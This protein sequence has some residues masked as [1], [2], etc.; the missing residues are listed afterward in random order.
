ML[1]ALVFALWK[2]VKN[3]IC[4]VDELNNEF[5]THISNPN[6]HHTRYTDEDA[7]NAVDASNKFIER[8]VM[9]DVTD[10]TGFKRNSYGKV[11]GIEAESNNLI[12]ALDV[13]GTKIKNTYFTYQQLFGAIG[14][15]ILNV[16][17]TDKNVQIGGFVF[18]KPNGYQY[19]YLILKVANNSGTPVTA[20]EV[21]SD[22]IDLKNHTIK[23][24]KNYN[25]ATLSGT[26]KIIEINIGGTPYYIK[27]YPNKS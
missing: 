18:L 14:F 7:V 20:F 26:P 5:D 16:E 15:P 6:A 1:K 23:D 12:A 2:K 13:M 17:G 3:L 10:V 25:D 8:N 27:A 19:S 22:K 11:L 24:I 4:D 21:Y 9:N